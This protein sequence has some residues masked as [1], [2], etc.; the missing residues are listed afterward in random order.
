MSE[1]AGAAPTR[2]K[3]A[4]ALARR[5]GRGQSA[6]SQSTTNAQRACSVD[7]EHAET[8][9][10]HPLD[11]TVLSPPEA[12]ASASSLS[13]LPP[14][15]LRVLAILLMVIIAII[16]INRVAMVIVAVSYINSNNSYYYY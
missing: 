14:R 1:D 6:S 9:R 11:C 7:R 4:R 3:A 13:G 2:L 12:T 15:L 10:T 5:S 8:K 16:T